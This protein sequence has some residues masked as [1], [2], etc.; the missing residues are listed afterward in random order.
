MGS[1]IRVVLADDSP[2]VRYHL[3]H[4]I[5]SAPDMVVVGEAQ[6]GVDV[7]QLVSD[8]QPDVVSMDINMPDMDGL[9]ATRQIMSQSPTPIVVVSSLL[10]I[11]VQLS[12]KAIEAGALAVVG[13]PSAQQNPTFADEQR[14]MLKVLR[15]MA[16]VKVIS[17]RQLRYLDAPEIITDAPRQ[18]RH[19][20]T[21]LIVIGAS[22]GGPRALLQLLRGLPDEPI[23]P[24]VIVQHMPEEF[25]AGLVQW[26][27]SAT[28]QQVFVAQDGQAL[29]S[30]MILIAPG[31]A[32][33]TIERANG[34][35][36]SRLHDAPT[37][38]RYTPS[39]DALFTSVA[40]TVG[41]QAIGVI[42]TGMGDDGARGL[43][44]MYDAGAMTIAQDELSATV[45]GMPR[46]AVAEGAAR[47]VVALENLA[48]QI[49][50]LL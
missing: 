41:E 9:E 25:I 23:A 48:T 45:Y 49:K 13:K 12:L 14:H 46:A 40:R 2:T 7:I 1:K 27:T 39:I 36:I 24:I 18:K 43:H 33:L 42:L 32:H 35:L 11:D 37:G 6:N 4:I 16:G 38:S 31:H 3:A 17:R 34:H 10:D 50:K 8:L 22:T 47:Y 21:E 5:D 29:Q 19:L 15:A 28:G 26:L 30:G 20:S 44:A